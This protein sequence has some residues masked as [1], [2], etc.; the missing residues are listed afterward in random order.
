M[1][2]KNNYKKLYTVLTSLG[3]LLFVH[4]VFSTV[5]CVLLLVLR[6]LV[7]NCCWLIV[8]I[9]VVVLCV[10]LFCVYLLYYVFIAVFPLDAGLLARSQYSEGSVTGHLDIGFS[11][12][13]CA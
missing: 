4:I 8:F 3:I 2:V 7:C 10:L 5:S 6:S 11:W 13:S 9:V 12:F 1:I